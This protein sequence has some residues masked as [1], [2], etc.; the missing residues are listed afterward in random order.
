MFL[1]SYVSA[2]YLKE[3]AK[4]NEENKSLK[5]SVKHR[6]Q[7]HEQKSKIFASTKSYKAKNPHAN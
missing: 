4:V 7:Q 6:C 5:I 3:K 1:F 2:R